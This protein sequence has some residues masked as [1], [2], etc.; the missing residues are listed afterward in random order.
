MRTRTRIIYILLG[1]LVLL[2]G[3]Q[4]LSGDEPQEPP[5]P[6]AETP[7]AEKTDPAPV[8]DL[9]KALKGDDAE[10]A[11]KAADG[12]VARGEDAIQ[13]LIDLQESAEGAPVERAAEALKRI[14][15]VDG[16]YANVRLF[17][18]EFSPHEIIGVRFVFRNYGKKPVTVF[19]PVSTRNVE[20]DYGL[21]WKLTL[22]TGEGK[23]V[24][25][26]DMNKSV[27]AAGLRGS[28]LIR[29]QPGARHDDI[30]FMETLF[31][32]EKLNEGEHV[33]KSMYTINKNL[34][35]G[36]KKRADLKIENLHEK[37][38]EPPPVSFKVSIP[39][40]KEVDRKTEEKIRKWI[41]E[42][43][44][45]EYKVRQNAEAELDKLGATA[46]KYLKETARTTED[47]QIRYTVE[48]LVDKIERPAGEMVAYLG[49][50]MNTDPSGTSVQVQSVM[51][52]SP[53]L[54]DGIK[55]GDVIISIDG[56][57]I[58]G[59]ANA[60]VGY[61]RK[62]IQSRREGDK[63]RITVLRAGKKETLEVT[64]GQIDRKTLQRG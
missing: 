52:S 34:L 64:L 15:V 2:A 9:I 14:G 30:V 63:V 3:R 60:G 5:A 21:G 57:K 6:D 47:P 17:R 51:D 55:A 42:L 4:M 25:A 22:Q 50:R 58:S 41:E 61:L 33:L 62:Q 8:E 7:P 12:L 29:L 31:G 53:A 38:V 48:Q 10:A 20:E 28:N 24:D 32:L 23:K 54:R 59:Y 56:S 35:E 18:D 13:P 1:L 37:P 49:I 40:Q 46:L 19:N 26:L 27:A 45:G 43:G 16:L 39:G 36:L 11:S 44:S